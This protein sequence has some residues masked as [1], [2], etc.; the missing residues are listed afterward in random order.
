MSQRGIAIVKLIRRLQQH[1]CCVCQ[2]Q[3]PVDGSAAPAPAELA[4]LEEWQRMQVPHEW[5]PTPTFWVRLSI[6]MERLRLEI[7]MSQACLYS[8]HRARLRTV[9]GCCCCVHVKYIQGSRAYR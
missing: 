7:V 3:Q 5:L 6:E 1:E 2:S 4:Q 8:W 9:P